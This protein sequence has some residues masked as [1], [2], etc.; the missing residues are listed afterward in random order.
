VIGWNGDRKI[1]A[2]IRRRRVSERSNLLN[3]GGSRQVHAHF[4]AFLAPLRECGFAMGWPFE[5]AFLPVEGHVDGSELCAGVNL[6]G[7]R[8]N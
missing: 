8:P 5:V 1:N 4:F 7:S 3:W 6:H 2:E